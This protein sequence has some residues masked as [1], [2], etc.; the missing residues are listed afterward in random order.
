MGVK[1]S[2]SSEIVIWLTIIIV[3]LLLIGWFFSNFVYE[4]PAFE[5]IENDLT[6]ISFM[7]NE[8]CRAFEYSEEYTPFILEGAL[9]LNEKKICIYHKEIENCK[10][11]FC[12]LNYQEINIGK[13]NSILVRKTLDKG[14]F[15]D[16]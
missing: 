9:I 5:L 1:A 6:R 7:I 2:S 12:D 4:R 15:I 14:V 10:N 16:E 3:I 8:A 13:I 11:V